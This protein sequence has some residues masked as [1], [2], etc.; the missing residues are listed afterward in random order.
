MIT[1][2]TAVTLLIALFGMGMSYLAQ[3]STPWEGDRFLAST[4]GGDCDY[5][6][7]MIC[8]IDRRPAPSAMNF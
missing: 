8:R 2:L 3:R 5:S 1:R 6:R 7:G 4:S